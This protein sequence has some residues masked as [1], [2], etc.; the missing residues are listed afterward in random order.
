VWDTGTNAQIAGIPF[1]APVAGIAFSPDGSVLAVATT[2][3]VV[4]LWSLATNAE[5]ASLSSSV[6]TT[7]R[8]KTVAFS[9]NGTQ[10][11][12]MGSDWAVRLWD[13]ATR[14]L[15]FTLAATPDQYPRQMVY[16]PDSALLVTGGDTSTFKAFLAVWDAASGVQVTNKT[17][18]DENVVGMGFNPDGN[19][20][21]CRRLAQL[22]C[23]G[24]RSKPP[25]RPSPMPYPHLLECLFRPHPQ[26]PCMMR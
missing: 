5:L 15:K 17:D 25:L 6:N 10:L 7:M 8:V 3:N 26:P 9:P 11:A 14:T 21:E 24:P 23:L 19:A 4:H 12:V 18:F 16:S 2:D 20:V 22:G 13:M 1:S